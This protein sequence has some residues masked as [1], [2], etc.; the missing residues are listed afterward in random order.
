MKNFYY[1]SNDIVIAG[2]FYLESRAQGTN[3]IVFSISEIMRSVKL[4]RWDTVKSIEKLMKV[5]VLTKISSNGKAK[6]IYRI[7]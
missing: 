7:E 6:T 2:F 1:N 5:G 4:E 3:E